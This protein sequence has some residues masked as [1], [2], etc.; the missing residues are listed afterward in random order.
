MTPGVSE[1]DLN[2]WTTNDM[3]PSPAISSLS[4]AKVVQAGVAAFSSYLYS[5][6]F[7]HV[8]SHMFRGRHSPFSSWSCA[9][10]RYPLQPDDIAA[11]LA[12][13][14]R[15]WASGALPR[16]RASRWRL[17][18]ASL[19]RILVRNK[20][21]VTRCRFARAKRW[22]A[23]TA[24]AAC[25]SATGAW[26][27]PTL[28]LATQPTPHTAASPVAVRRACA[29]ALLAAFPWTTMHERAEG[30]LSLS[31]LT[32]CILLSPNERQPKRQRRGSVSVCLSPVPG[33]LP[34]ALTSHTSS[35]S[36]CTSS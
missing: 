35:H 10:D 19:P 33:L 23:Q 28:P 1:Q 16:R 14:Y 12:P 24:R 9:L 27:G 3:L 17:Q 5:S 6:T 25:P 21:A 30:Q 8:S 31:S 32:F 34:A 22:R 7:S 20:H 18:T 4:G 2:E 26:R 29:R 13:L 15:R 36:F 11:S